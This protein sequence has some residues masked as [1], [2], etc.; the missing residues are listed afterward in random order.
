MND[1]PCL[2]SGSY[3]CTQHY[4]VQARRRMANNKLAALARD[5]DITTEQWCQLMYL[6]EVDDLDLLLF[7]GEAS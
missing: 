2:C 1:H 4:T 6:H 7:E 5:F 3:T